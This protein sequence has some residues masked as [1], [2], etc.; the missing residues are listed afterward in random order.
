MSLNYINVYLKFNL[1]ANVGIFSCISG[2][3]YSNL[4]IMF[5][6]VIGAVGRL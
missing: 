5:E 6:I 4:D 1:S 3:G 2:M